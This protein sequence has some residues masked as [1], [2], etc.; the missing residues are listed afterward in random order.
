MSQLFDLRPFSISW[1]SEAIA[2]LGP[3]ISRWFL[4]CESTVQSR[5]FSWNLQ[6]LVLLY[7]TPVNDLILVSI[8]VY[9][10]VFSLKKALKINEDR[11]EG[12]A[13]ERQRHLESCVLVVDMWKKTVH[14]ICSQFNCVLP[15]LE[16]LETQTFQGVIP[17]LVPTINPP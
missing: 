3:R 15:L 4:D 10:N 9:D 13:E 8:G 5:L 14:L 1:K 12:P 17:R 16:V 11:I 7:H 2:G 6:T